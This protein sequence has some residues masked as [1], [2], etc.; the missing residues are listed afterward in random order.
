MKLYYY[1]L[2]TYSQKVQLAFYEKGLT[3]NR[4]VIDLMDE[5]AVAAFEII[6]PIGRVPVLQLESTDDA[7]HESTHIIPESSIII[8][9][10][11]NQFPDSPL[12]IP[13][14]NDAARAVR[15]MDRMC[16]FYLNDPITGLVRNK[17]FGSVEKV[18]PNKRSF[19][20]IDANYDYLDQHLENNAFLCG[21][22]FSMAD[23]AY[24]PCLYYARYVYPFAEHENIRAYWLRALERPSVKKLLE[25]VDRLWLP[26]AADLFPDINI[27]D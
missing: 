11:D 2:S 22:N 5:N 14:D 24:I 10:L 3:F 18:I 16:D 25:E 21:N 1:P 13:Q 26:M 4:E 17:I 23:C 19:K 15:F 6:Y 8:E 7:P 12:L 9:Y 20:Y 27:V